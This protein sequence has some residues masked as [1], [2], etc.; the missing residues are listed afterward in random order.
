MFHVQV[1]R[2]PLLVGGAFLTVIVA[3]LIPIIRG[4]DLNVSGAGPFNQ[5]AEVL[6]T[7]NN[8]LP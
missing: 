3:S 7:R 1:M 6:F 2:A 5:R 8:I 4:A